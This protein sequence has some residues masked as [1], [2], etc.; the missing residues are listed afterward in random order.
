MCVWW[1]PSFGVIF[2]QAYR[3]FIY[4][5]YYIFC[6]SISRIC[7]RACVW[8]QECDLWDY[9]IENIALVTYWLLTLMKCRLTTLALKSMICLNNF[10]QAHHDL[11]IGT[12]W[13]RLCYKNWGIVIGHWINS[14]MIK[15]ELWKH[16]PPFKNNKQHHHH[17]HYHYLMHLHVD[18]KCL[19][20]H[21]DQSVFPDL[22]P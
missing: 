21:I 14:Q 22:L 3:M 9:G 17:R 13:L 6:L 10:L 20:F 11:T 2:L 18:I 4:A 7:M 16:C 12:N 15:R 19:V 8:V 1:N 5:Y